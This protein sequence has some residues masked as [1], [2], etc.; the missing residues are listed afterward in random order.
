[1]VFTSDVAVVESGEGA[2]KETEG[3]EQK[4]KRGLWSVPRVLCVN[5]REGNS[6]E[7]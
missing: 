4:D 6:E 3:N 5:E 2:D 1:M 7:V